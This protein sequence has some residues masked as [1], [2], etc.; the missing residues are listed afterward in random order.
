MK[1]FSTRG[2]YKLLETTKQ[3]QTADTFENCLEPGTGIAQSSEKCLVFENN[4]PASATQVG[5]VGKMAVFHSV[6]TVST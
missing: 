5:P 1:A 4:P 6:D 3:L 2:Q